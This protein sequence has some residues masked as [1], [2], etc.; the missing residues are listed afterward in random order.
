[1]AVGNACNCLLLRHDV[2]AVVFGY[3]GVDEVA[4]LLCTSKHCQ[5]QVLQHLRGTNDAA[6]KL[7]LAAAQD[8]AKTMASNK[9]WK[10][11]QSTSADQALQRFRF[12]TNQVQAHTD[13]QATHWLVCA[14]P[15]ARSAF[16]GYCLVQGCTVSEWDLKVSSPLWCHHALW[17]GQM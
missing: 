3:L 2:I 9:S 8:A 12:L 4:R 5:Q 17:L 6:R 10:S 7:V 16:V 14:M 15:D 13:K 11:R 1:M